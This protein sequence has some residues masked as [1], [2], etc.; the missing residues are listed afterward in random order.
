MLY[1]VHH[2]HFGVQIE[3]G[4]QLLAFSKKQINVKGLI[5]EGSRVL[6]ENRGI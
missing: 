5:K 4:H 3:S 6:E 1:Y 2:S